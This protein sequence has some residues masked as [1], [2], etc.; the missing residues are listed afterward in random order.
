[1]LRRPPRSTRTDTLFPYTT[2]FRSELVRSANVAGAFD[3]RPLV[4][5]VITFAA[6]GAGEAAGDAVDQR[7][8]VDDELNDVIELNSFLFEQPFERFRLG[9]GARV[10]VEAE[11]RSHVDR[12][13][14]VEGK[15]V[16][17][18]DLGG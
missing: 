14:E 16:S 11:A 13:R 8:L 18:V 2:L 10:A 15:R 3:R 7:I 1:M 12:K 4:T 17:S 9:G 5:V 6:D